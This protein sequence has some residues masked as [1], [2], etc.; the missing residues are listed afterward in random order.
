MF[1][2]LASAWTFELERALKPI[3]MASDTAASDMSDSIIAPV[4]ECIIF[5]STSSLDNL[6]R[7]SLKASIEPCTSALMI[8]FS[9]LVSPSCIFSKSFSRLNLLVFESSFDRCF[10]VRYKLTCLALLSSASAINSSPAL[11][12]PIR[13]NTSTG[14]EGPAVSTYIPL[15]F[16]MARIFP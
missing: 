11:G 4:A 13:P 14:I 16:N 2:S 5:I 1:S 9:S 6:I 7:E 12:T 8:R 3:I 10:W 15:S